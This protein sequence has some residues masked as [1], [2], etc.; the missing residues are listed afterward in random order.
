[1]FMKGLGCLTIHTLYITLQP[2]LIS[3]RNLIAIIMVDLIVSTSNIDGSPRDVTYPG[4]VSLCSAVFVLSCFKFSL[5]CQWLIGVATLGFDGQ[6]FLQRL[7][8]KKIMFIGDSIS[9]NQ[10]ESLLCLLHAA[11]PDSRIIEER[12]SFYSNTTFESPTTN[13]AG[14]R[15]TIE[16]ADI[17]ESLHSGRLKRT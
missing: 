15:D 11:V 3:A 17:I 16:E 13:L 8:G 5:I 6:D 7:K 9:L 14:L 10:R 12:N 2:A 1:M 4:T